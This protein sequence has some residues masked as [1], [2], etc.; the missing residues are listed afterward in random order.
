VKNLII[1]PSGTMKNPI[2]NPE[3]RKNISTYHL[4]CFNSSSV[5]INI[6]S[7]HNRR[8]AKYH[9]IPLGIRIS[10]NREKLPS[11]KRDF[12]HLMN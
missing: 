8:H 1:V 3:I 10:G 4:Y 9:S 2:P 6:N 5:I 7:L 12:K 11:V